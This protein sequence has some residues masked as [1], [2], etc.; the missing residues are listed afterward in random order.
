[1]P[2]QQYAVAGKA[3]QIRLFN[4]PPSGQAIPRAPLL[5]RYLFPCPYQSGSSMAFPIIGLVLEGAGWSETAK[6]L[7]FSKDHRKAL[8]LCHLCWTRRPDGATESPGGDESLPGVSVPVY[9]HAR[10][11]DLIVTVELPVPEDVPP[12]VWR[13]RGVALLAWGPPV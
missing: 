13:Q 3:D 7:A 9:L 8:A 5:R 1:M 10:R 2:P 12:L 4:A 11:S 6:T